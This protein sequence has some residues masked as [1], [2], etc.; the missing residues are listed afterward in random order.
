MVVALSHW[1]TSAQVRRRSGVAMRS[2]AH[3]LRRLVP[4]RRCPYLRT[5]VIALG[6]IA[7]VL[8][9][10]LAACLARDPADLEE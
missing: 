10:K 2:L 6:V 1:R 9:Y 7:I 8:G 3:S 4:A 5:T